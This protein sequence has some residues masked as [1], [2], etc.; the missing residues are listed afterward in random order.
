MWENIVKTIISTL[1]VC[2]IYSYY[3]QQLLC[4]KNYK[5]FVYRTK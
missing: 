5:Q 4:Y 2:Q 1:G 3:E